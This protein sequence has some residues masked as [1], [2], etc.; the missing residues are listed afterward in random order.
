MTSSAD[1]LEALKEILIETDVDVSATTRLLD[2]VR[3]HRGSAD[4]RT[5]LRGELLKLLDVGILSRPVGSRTHVVM[6]VGANGT[7]KTTAVDR[8]AR[9]K[10]LAGENP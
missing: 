3:V 7:G 10:V 1:T 4:L 6:V 5:V 9:L 2:V 8:L